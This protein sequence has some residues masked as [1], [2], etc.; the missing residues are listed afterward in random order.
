M[1]HQLETDTFHLHIMFQSDN[2]QSIMV[3]KQRDVDRVL[4]QNRSTVED[5]VHS[6]AEVYAD[7]RVK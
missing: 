6:Y 4:Q 1:Y 5:L 2:I 7:T 3:I